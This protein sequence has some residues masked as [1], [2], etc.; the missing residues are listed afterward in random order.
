MKIAIRLN[1]G[2][3]VNGNPRRVFVVIDPK[4]GVI[5]AIDEGYEGE[6]GLKRAHR[7]TSS[8]DFMTT[9][10]EYRGLLREAEETRRMMSGRSSRRSR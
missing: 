9:P 1:A 6:A 8:A 5:D 3:D 4:H 7:I 10:G 2:H